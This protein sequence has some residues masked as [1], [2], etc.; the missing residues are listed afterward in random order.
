MA[1][2]DFVAVAEIVS[3]LV[4]DGAVSLDAV[5]E[6]ELLVDIELPGGSGDPDSVLCEDPGTEA[7]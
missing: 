7:E 3:S 2:V 4:P 5:S 6:G 1:V